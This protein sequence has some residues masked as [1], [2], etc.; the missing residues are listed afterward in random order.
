MVGKSS[1]EPT[2]HAEKIWPPPR[3]DSLSSVQRSVAC[4]YFSNTE[5]LAFII[6]KGRYRSILPDAFSATAAIAWIISS[7]L[8]AS[9]SVANLA[10]TCVFCSIRISFS[11][12]EGS[13]V[14]LRNTI[15]RSDS[16][17][18]VKNIGHFKVPDVLHSEDGVWARNGVPQSHQAALGHWEWDSDATEDTSLRLFSERERLSSWLDLLTFI[19]GVHVPILVNK[20]AK[21]PLKHCGETCWP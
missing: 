11:M 6:T 16:V 4:G 21:Q 9:G 18:T 20:G 17:F 5:S 12:S 1:P 13:L 19:L 7:V 15:P 8:T 14:G 2:W 3:N 10:T